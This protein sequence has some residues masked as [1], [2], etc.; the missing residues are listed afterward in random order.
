M[1]LYLGERSPTSSIICVLQPPGVPEQFDSGLPDVK[2]REAAD[3]DVL[4]ELRDVLGD[5]LLHGEARLAEVRLLQKTVLLQEILDLA[6]DD[7][8]DDLL[9]LAILERLGLENVLLRDQDL[10]RHVLA[11]DPARLVSRDL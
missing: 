2:P 8:R 4:L 9:G 7:L 1:R 5:V 3:R 6:L 10:V 11:R